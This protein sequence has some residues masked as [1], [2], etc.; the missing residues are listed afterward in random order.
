MNWVSGAPEYLE[1]R[2]VKSTRILRAFW[3][4]VENYILF[5][6]LRNNP[7]FAKACALENLA[8]YRLNLIFLHSEQLTG[9]FGHLG[10]R[11]QGT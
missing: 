8:I 3:S 9:V 5:R 1:K 7:V 2:Y 10:I 11:V 6:I 4:P